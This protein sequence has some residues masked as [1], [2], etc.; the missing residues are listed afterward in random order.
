MT[1]EIACGFT[2]RSVQVSTNDPFI[3]TFGLAGFCGATE[4]VNTTSINIANVGNFA[5]ER[6]DG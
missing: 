2:V 1:F 6:I 3:N 5:E 4:L